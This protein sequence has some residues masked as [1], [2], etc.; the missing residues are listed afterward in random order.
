M[1]GANVIWRCSTPPEHTVGL[2]AGQSV[3]CLS[4]PRPGLTRFCVPQP[5]KTLVCG[6]HDKTPSRLGFIAT[7]IK[8]T[9]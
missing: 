7:E 2:N 8:G 5:R 6:W 3:R 4:V 9:L 1:D